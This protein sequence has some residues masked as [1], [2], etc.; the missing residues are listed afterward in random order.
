MIDSIEQKSLSPQRGG[1]RNTLRD[2]LL[3]AEV[4]QPG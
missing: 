4:A 2:E 1:K 3:H